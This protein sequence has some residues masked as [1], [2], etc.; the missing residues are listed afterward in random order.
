MDEASVRVWACRT[1]RESA[2]AARYAELV[3]ADVAA[4]ARRLRSPAARAEALI[5]GAFMRAVLA[6]E[7][8]IAPEQL[9]FTSTC[10]WCGDP[11]H[12]KPA[13]V[14]AGAAPPPC[15][16]LAHTAGLALLAVGAAEVGVDV[17]RA[18]R[19][20]VADGNELVLSTAERGTLPA[21]PGDLGTAYLSS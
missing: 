16:S 12:G 2:D 3:P 4:R 18:G 19:I 6:E 8:G 9:A 13:L 17:E 1:D 14:A 10:S 15:F 7:T 5:A 20:G 11:A 21:H